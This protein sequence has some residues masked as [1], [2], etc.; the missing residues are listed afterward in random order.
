MREWIKSG[1]P[2]IW[3]T[4]GAVAIAVLA[5]TGVMALTAL[6]GLGHFWPKPVAEMSFKERDGRSTGLIG[7]MRDREEVAVRRLREAGF[8][9]PGDSPF[10]ERVLVKM[11]NRD[12]T[13]A[14]FR[15]YPLPLLGEVS[16]PRGIVTI[17][18]LVRRL[19]SSTESR[20]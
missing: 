6:R 3:L 11:G 14:D 1:S 9:I 5:V 16:Y 12:V 8:V 13:G 17:E 2:W 20:A 19:V 7:E 4:A 15:W 10:T 18:D